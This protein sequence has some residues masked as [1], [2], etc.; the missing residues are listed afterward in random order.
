MRRSSRA[1]QTTL[2]LTSVIVGMLEQAK[3]DEGGVSFWLPGT[4]GSLAA[5]PGIPGWNFASIYDHTSVSA[6]RNV[7]FKFGSGVQAGLKSQ[8]DLVFIN[9]TYVFAAPVLGAQASLSFA[10]AFGRAT[11]TVN[12]TLTGPN[13]SAISGSRN[14]S[15][16]S[17]SDLYPT[18]S[19]KWNFGVHNIMVYTAWDVPLGDYNSKR[20]A[21]IGIGHWAADAGAGYTYFNPQTGHE[22]SAVTGLTYNFINPSTNYQNGVDWHLDWGASQFLSKQVFIGLVGYLYDQVTNDSGSGAILG[23]FKSRV[24]GVGPQVGLLFP[25]N[26]AY[27]GYLN[28]KAYREFWAEHRPEGWNAWVT[29]AV[30]P[31]APR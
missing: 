19:L 27:Q 6:D 23:P 25:V 2:L 20:L 31:V 26:D 13:G 22:F 5:A 14:D 18:A 28:L 30:S 1:I 11:T 29:F 3:A 8:A 15:L 10:E 16:T 9:A 4:Y 21:N 7:E 24:A 12:A 17:F